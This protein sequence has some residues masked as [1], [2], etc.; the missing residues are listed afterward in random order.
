MSHVKF[1]GESDGDIDFLG[2]LR[3]TTESDLSQNMI[4]LKINHS[5]P[6]LSDFGCS[7]NLLSTML[8]D[9]AT[10]FVVLSWLYYRYWNTDLVN[11]W[12][13]KLLVSCEY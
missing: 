3:K 2:K 9:D 5:R 8:S 10:F 11:I 4:I 12:Y 6:I 1:D 13:C 7:L